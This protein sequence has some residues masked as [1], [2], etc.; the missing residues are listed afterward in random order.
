MNLNI[1][2]R[3]GIDNVHVPNNTESIKSSVKHQGFIF[4][5]VTE[6]EVLKSIYSLK[7]TKSVGIDDIKKNILKASA[8]V[9]VKSLTHLINKSL[10]EGNF[11]ADGKQLKLSLSSKRVTKCRRT[12]TDLFP[13]C[14][15]FLRYWKR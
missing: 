5:P 15:V 1:R 6:D 7:N 8:P 10:L 12:I 14:H 13:C 9:I 4:S 11:L 2:K 3:N